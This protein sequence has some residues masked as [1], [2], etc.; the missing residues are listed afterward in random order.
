MSEIQSSNAHTGKQLLIAGSL[1]TLCG[2]FLYS[3]RMGLA[4]FFFGAQFL[5][6]M[7]L[8]NLDVFKV[9][10][11]S[12]GS[13]ITILMGIIILGVGA[14]FFAKSSAPKSEDSHGTTAA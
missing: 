14:A 9:F 4:G 2:M 1:C 10:T 11:M 3:Q 8:T 7:P 13:L 5:W 12:A 6:G